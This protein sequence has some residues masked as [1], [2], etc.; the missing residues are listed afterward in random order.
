MASTPDDPGDL[1][2]SPPLAPVLIADYDEYARQYNSY[3][4]LMASYEAR[5]TLDRESRTPR[6][7]FATQSQ[8]VRFRDPPPAYSTPFEEPTR[9]I[10]PVP[11]SVSEFSSPAR[12][13][14]VS[15]T[16]SPASFR[17]GA[18]QET[19]LWL[20]RMSASTELHGS[21]TEQ[22]VR[23][24]LADVCEHALINHLKNRNRSP[25]S[26]RSLNNLREMAI[27]KTTE[28]GKALMSKA[29][30]QALRGT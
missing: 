20:A 8:S 12:E 22:H 25:K 4:S 30:W 29:S 13:R 18:R 21:P 16:R 1:Q 23:Y 19:N 11:T 2:L 9:T 28:S 17:G 27:R 15:R 6:V 5:A 7:T 24:A 26:Y 14:A 3:L 10:I